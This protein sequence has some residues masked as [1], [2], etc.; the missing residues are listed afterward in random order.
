MC[1]TFILKNRNHLAL[2]QGYDFYYG[3]GLIITNKRGIKK[4]A[5]CELLT[6]YNLYDEALKTPRWTSKY[7]S[8]TFNQFAREIPTCGIN[9][10]G[11]AIVSMWHD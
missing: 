2:A 5:L 9:E 1:T 10:K 6:K 4:V 7:G 3:H 11:L 8:I